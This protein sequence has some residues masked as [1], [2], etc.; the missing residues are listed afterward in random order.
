ML[1]TS[2]VVMLGLTVALATVFGLHG[3]ALAGQFKTLNTAGLGV[4][5]SISAHSSPKN[6][7]QAMEMEVYEWPT[8]STGGNYRCQITS[9]STGQT[10]NLR[11]IGV[12]G[13]II[14]SCAAA[15]GGTCSTPTAALVGNLKFM[16]LVATQFG[17]PVSS[18]AHYV[19]AVQRQ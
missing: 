5:G 7:G 18:S 4:G 15:N 17:A 16:C 19:I 2:M 1:R 6:F 13:T 14:S 9:N 8:A 12:N 11:L 3:E 10:L